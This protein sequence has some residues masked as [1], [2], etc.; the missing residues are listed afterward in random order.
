[1]HWLTRKKVFN[2]NPNWWNWVCE[3]R[4]QIYSPFHCGV[5]HTVLHFNLS[6]ILQHVSFVYA[7]T[8]RLLGKTNRGH[9]KKMQKNLL[10][11]LTDL[12][13]LTY[14]GWT[15]TSAWG[16]WSPQ[17][18]HPQQHGTSIYFKSLVLKHH[19]N[20]RWIITKETS[21]GK[22][23]WNTWVTTIYICLPRWTQS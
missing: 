6:I 21:L 1:M 3:T 18:P 20:W 4:R 13:T 10:H 12:F 2:L 22:K 17:G 11:K 8:K 19:P 15:T 23:L 5:V 16:L 9:N 7:Q 14:W